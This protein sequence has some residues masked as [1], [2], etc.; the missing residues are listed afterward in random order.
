APPPASLETLTQDVRRVRLGAADGFLLGGAD[1]LTETWEAIRMSRA[2]IEEFRTRLWMELEDPASA[3]P[4]WA[5]RFETWDSLS[6]DT[7]QQA[8]DE[9][10]FEP[11]MRFYRHVD[12][13]FLRL[14][15][16]TDAAIR[17]AEP[18]AP[19]G[20]SM[21]TC[22]DEI[23][24]L[25]HGAAAAVELIAT[26]PDRVSMARTAAYRSPAAQTI[27]CV[28]GAATPEQAGWWP[29]HAL[30]NRHAGLWWNLDAGPEAV[31]DGPMS[32]DPVFAEVLD[33]TKAVRAGFAD[34]FLMAKPAEP[35]I[36]IYD[37]RASELLRAARKEP[38]RAS[39][40]GAL[41]ILQRLGFAAELVASEDSRSDDLTKY[42]WLVLPGLDALSDAEVQRIRAFVRAGGLVLADI[43]PGA[44]DE[45]GRPR[46]DLPLRD[47]FTML[48]PWE[49]EPPA[50]A[51][52]AASR[53]PQKSHGAYLLNQSFGE[54]FNAESLELLETMF[55]GARCE[56]MFEIN[57][58]D[59][60]IGQRF[61]FRY[62][63]ALVYAALTS[64]N[65]PGR[66]KYELVIPQ[67]G[68]VYN[69]QAGLEVRRPKHI[70]WRAMPGSVALFSALPYRVTAVKTAVPD[71]VRPGNR[72]HC[73]C[74]A[75]WSL[76]P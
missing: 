7:I 2:V 52:P 6:L 8:A 44:F 23:S 66:A 24:P 70:R 19:L 5:S 71:V 72:L 43:P 60:F 67:E 34:L 69:M 14:Y 25:W 32:V 10:F 12:E 21:T 31:M 61:R 22:P 13:V 51:D 54:S 46:K 29:W 18:F 30:L 1:G 36:A 26:P 64:P 47:L 16:M 56:E 65:Q 68:Y 15:G 17:A 40:A 35:P 49:T 3:G 42:K 11:W 27:L 33:Q 38:P 37:S 55:R 50:D 4:D 58:A 75:C 39:L 74:L 57:G 45:L 20:F 73:G 41:A 9:S 53:T 63:K 28:P 48:T 62:G 76:R 59:P